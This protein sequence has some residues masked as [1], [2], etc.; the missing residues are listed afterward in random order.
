[1]SETKTVYMCATD[2]YHELGEAPDGCELFPTVEDLKDYKGC[3]DECGIVEVK[4]TLSKV[5]QVGTF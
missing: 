2:W 4:V 3:T 5:V 1:M